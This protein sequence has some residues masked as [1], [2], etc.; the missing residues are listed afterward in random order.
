MI[1]FF[2]WFIVV[3]LWC[4]VVKERKTEKEPRW[5]IGLTARRQL[6]FEKQHSKMACWLIWE[7]HA[8]LTWNPFKCE[9]ILV[10]QWHTNLRI[11][12]CFKWTIHNFTKP[13]RPRAPQIKC[14]NSNKI[15]P[16]EKINWDCSNDSYVA[17]FWISHLLDCSLN[18][19]LSALSYFRLSINK[20]KIA[21][22]QH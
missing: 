15:K 6:W 12:A 1:Q 18:V 8:V 13:A 9:E 14:C 10:A 20:V 19:S 3:W 4:D 22:N 2:V 16:N 17:L 21:Q 7:A 11:S 5:F